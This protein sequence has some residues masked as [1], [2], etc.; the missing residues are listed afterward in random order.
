[1][2][3]SN[4]LGL[5]WPEASDLADGPDA[6]QD[7]ALATD[8][9]MTGLRSWIADRANAGGGDNMLT[10]YPTGTSNLHTRTIPVVAVGWAEIEYDVSV[11]QTASGGA[12]AVANW[13]GL[14]R[15]YI[16]EQLAGIGRIHNRNTTK[17][18]KGRAVAA[19]QLPKSYSASMILRIEGANDPTSSSAFSF[20]EY[21]L[22]IRQYGALRA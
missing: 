9:K 2:G 21:D 10:V 11:F 15:M 18:V 1:M 14:L 5:P 17:Y 13:G 16:N 12:V 7:L 19:V 8:Q 4:E 22:N 20:A 6:V 3:A